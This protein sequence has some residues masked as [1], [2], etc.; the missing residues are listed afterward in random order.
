MRGRGTTQHMPFGHA[1]CAQVDAFMGIVAD[2][3]NVERAAR[4]VGRSTAWGMRILS[5]WEEAPGSTRAGGGVGREP[6][7]THNRTLRTGDSC[8]DNL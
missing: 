6:L 4:A 3:D 1:T 2:T 5:E 8:G 7:D